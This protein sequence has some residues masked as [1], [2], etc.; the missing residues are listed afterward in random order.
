MKYPNPH[1]A[2]WVITHIAFTLSTGCF[3]KAETTR[4][5][6]IYG[7][8]CTIWTYVVP[9]V[10]KFVVGREESPK[11]LLLLLAGGVKGEVISGTILCYYIPIRTGRT[12]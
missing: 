2:C 6:K 9:Y 7:T 11:N 12:L 3:T 5:A 1:L 8:P 10:T 4:T